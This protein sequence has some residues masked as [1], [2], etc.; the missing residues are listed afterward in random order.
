MAHVNIPAQCYNTHAEDDWDDDVNGH[1]AGVDVEAGARS[2]ECL[3]E[4]S[5]VA[6]ED[7]RDVIRG[8][9]RRDVTRV[10]RDGDLVRT[11][12]HRIV[13]SLELDGE[14][15]VSRLLGIG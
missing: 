10:R 14:M 11:D 15:C 7:D 2:P 8:V 3:R 13:T 5:R 1:R 4:G 9:R 12:A 6:R